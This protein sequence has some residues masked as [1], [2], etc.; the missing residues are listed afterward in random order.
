MSERWVR[1]RK[2]EGMPHRSSGNRTPY[3]ISACEHWLED[4]AKNPR[5]G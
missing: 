3:K 5:R 4:H 2:L 1:D